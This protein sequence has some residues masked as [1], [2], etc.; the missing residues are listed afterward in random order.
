VLS[1][2]LITLL[3]FEE[4]RFTGT[5]SLRQFYMRRTLR[6]FPLYFLSL[7]IAPLLQYVGL[8]RLSSCTYW[9]AFTYTINFAPKECV[10]TSYSHF[11]SLAVEEHFY[12]LWPLIFLLCRRWALVITVL[13]VLIC[14]IVSENGY[15]WFAPFSDKYFVNRWTI[16]AA[17]PIAVGCI[18]AYL[19][20]NKYLARAF[21]KVGGIILGASLFAIV[22][23]WDNN[24]GVCLAVLGVTIFIFL[25]QNAA[26]TRILE[27]R[28]LAWIGTISYGLYVW[29]GV[30]GGN[31]TYREFPA[32]PPPLYEGLAWAFVASVASFYLFEKPIMR[33]KH[34]FTW[35]RGPQAM[36]VVR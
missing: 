22:Y 27:W 35:R 11:W 33:L 3:L 24:F 14:W 34:R 18:G 5:V 16:P 9:F 1:G 17:A 10:F 21:E 30:L 19:C 12:L 28:P 15:S 26:L 7:L 32:F 36:S 4:M 25:K 29:Q 31:G 6:I 20:G 23:P 8:I 2:F 13:F